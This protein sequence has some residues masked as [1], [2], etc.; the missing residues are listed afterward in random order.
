MRKV[1]MQNQQ[2][3]FENYL[4]HILKSCHI[5]KVFAT[6]KDIKEGRVYLNEFNKPE[7]EF[8]QKK[9]EII[10]FIIKTRSD[11]IISLIDNMRLVAAQ[12]TR[13]IPL[14]QLCKNNLYA[15]LSFEVESL[16]IKGMYEVKKKQQ[17]EFK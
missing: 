17:S 16:I 7:N 3:I 1:N 13:T 12:V 10:N 4:D 2:N 15:N 9:N 14:N 5:P 11:A 6:L 8:L